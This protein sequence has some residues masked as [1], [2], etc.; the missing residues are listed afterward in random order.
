MHSSHSSHHLTWTPQLVTP[1]ADSQLQLKL[2]NEL[3]TAEFKSFSYKFKPRTNGED[4][5]DYLPTVQG[6]VGNLGS[7]HLL[8]VFDTNHQTKMVL[9]TLQAIHGIMVGPFDPSITNTT[10]GS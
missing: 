10:R 1:M 9:G 2:R 8:A 6:F 3:I 7:L 4:K 5:I